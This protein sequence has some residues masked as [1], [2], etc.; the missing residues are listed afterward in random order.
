MGGQ[1]GR[2]DIFSNDTSNSSGVAI[3]LPSNIDFELCEKKCDNESR[4]LLLK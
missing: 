1:M 2:K 3:L 4:L